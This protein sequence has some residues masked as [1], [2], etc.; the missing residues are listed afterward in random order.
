LI[1]AALAH[2]FSNFV[3]SIAKLVAHGGELFFV[4]ITVV[5]PVECAHDAF[6][7]NRPPRR[8]TI[9]R[10]GFLSECR[11]CQHAGRD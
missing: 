5:I 6:T 2:P 3:K 8:I 10:L 1:A 7:Q 9:L 11:Q 4:Q